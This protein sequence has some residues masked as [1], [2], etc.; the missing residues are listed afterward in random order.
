MSRE[1]NKVRVV[2]FD[3]DT[4][5]MRAQ[6]KY[7]YGYTQIKK[8]LKNND[9]VHHQGSGYW[10]KK[11]VD[12]MAVVDIVEKMVKEMEWIR[13]C[14]KNIEILDDPGLNITQL[15]TGAD[16]N[17]VRNAIRSHSKKISVEKSGNAA[18]ET[19]DKA[20][21]LRQFEK[22]V[23]AGKKQVNLRNGV[24]KDTGKGKGR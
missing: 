4:K 18:Q 13:T 9:F 22:D 14:T 17:T 5:K 7:P 12:R 6:G 2:H 16:A 15:V 21:G 19:N 8:Y 10:T 23:A 11:P 3:F 24:V 1:K 20:A